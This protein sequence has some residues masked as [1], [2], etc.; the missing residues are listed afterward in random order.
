MQKLVK[1]NQ[2]SRQS[3]SN[4]NFMQSV[5]FETGIRSQTVSYS[6]CLPRR[7]GRLSC[8]SA[9]FVTL[10]CRKYDYHSTTPCP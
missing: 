2:K 5:F 10:H 1:N 4:H 8:P 7:D 3:N 9:Y 6:I